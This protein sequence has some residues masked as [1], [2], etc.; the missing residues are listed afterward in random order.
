M[1]QFFNKII[2]FNNITCFFFSNVIY[3][4]SWLLICQVLISVVQYAP[5]FVFS[6]SL[7]VDTIRFFNEYLTLYYLHLQTNV[8]F[9]F[10]ETLCRREEFLFA[11]IDD[12]IS[13]WIFAIYN[14]YVDSIDF[15]VGPKQFLQYLWHHQVI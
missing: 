10:R 14:F 13:R 8:I 15:M 2:N 7:M 12:T 6:L 1:Y 11:L 5:K 4:Y 3:C 9:T